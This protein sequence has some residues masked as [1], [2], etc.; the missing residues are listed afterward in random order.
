M[1]KHRSA[2]PTVGVGRA[3]GGRP[4]FKSC[5]FHYGP[6]KITDGMSSPPCITVCQG[7]DAEQRRPRA[8]EELT[9]WKRKV[10]SSDPS[11]STKLL[12]GKCL[13]MCREVL[14]IRDIP[15]GSELCLP[16][17]REDFR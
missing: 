3:G 12:K 13:K 14:V 4:L 16:K 9:A 15:G 11:T 2:A 7:T 10:T 5:S 8:E 1:K 6:V 17:E